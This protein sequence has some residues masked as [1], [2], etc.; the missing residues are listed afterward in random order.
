M[1]RGVIS[2]DQWGA[3]PPSQNSGPQAYDQGLI[4]HWEGPKMWGDLWAFAHDSCYEKVRGIQRY[5]MSHGYSDI[6][7]N[8]VVCPHGYIFNGRSGVNM[9][10]AASGNWDVNH[11]TEA[12]CFL[13]GDGDDILTNNPDPI[14]ALNAARNYLMSGPMSSQ[15]RPHRSIVSTSCPGDAL[16]YVAGLLNGSGFQP[17]SDGDGSPAPAP[18]P[19]PAPVDNQPILQRGSTGPAVADWQSWLNQRTQAGLVVDGDFG[20]ATEGAVI[21]F[22]QFWH[23]ANPEIMVDGIIGPQTW[24]LRAL[25]EY[26]AT[27][28]AP[29]PEPAPA[30]APEPAPAPAPAP[31]PEPEPEPEPA[32]EKMFTVAEIEIIM[33]VISVVCPLMREKKKQR[34]REGLGNLTV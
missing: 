18:A 3:Q 21:R 23:N 17:Y 9:A 28:P 24:D 29:A 4:L 13:W 30:P 25:T 20:P 31:A 5:H 22:Q 1:F 14:D 32:P 26:L 16:T 15:V 8:D 34:I 19:A 10:N 33:S 12:I 7:Y 27:R 6:A 11:H 2:R